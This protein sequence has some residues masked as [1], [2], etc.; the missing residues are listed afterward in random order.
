MN[1]FKENLWLAIGTINANKLR[2]C[3]TILGVVIGVTCVISIGA[4]LTGLDR[5]FI[6]SIEGFGVN[7]VFVQKM[8]MGPHFGRPSR[9]ERMRKPISWDNY[10]VVKASCTACRQVL[11]TIYGQTLDKAKYKNIELQGP[12]FQG[13]LS[14]FADVMNMNIVNGRM[15]TEVE[16]EH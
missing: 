5:S 15:F 13:S 8:G 3:L 2:S 6:R 1:G 11:V 7:N 10:E 14:N 12:D 9:E 4:I 16:N